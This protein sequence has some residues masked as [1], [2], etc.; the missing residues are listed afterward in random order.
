MADCYETSADFVPGH[1]LAE[2]AKWLSGKGRDAM[3]SVGLLL[4]Q[5]AALT[6]LP[7]FKS[8]EEFAQ[9]SGRYGTVLAC[10]A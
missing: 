5:L 6:A 2:S 7:E 3:F 4:I 1:F 8:L 10:H 9:V